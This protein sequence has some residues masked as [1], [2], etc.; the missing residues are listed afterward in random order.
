MWTALCRCIESLWLNFFILP[1]DLLCGHGN[2]MKYSR[3]NNTGVDLLVSELP[4]WSTSSSAQDWRINEGGKRS[5]SDSIL[6]Q[7]D[8]TPYYKL[9]IQ[10]GIGN[11]NN[12]ELCPPPFIF[13]VHYESI[14][15][16]T[17]ESITTSL[18]ECQCYI[19]IFISLNIKRKH[20]SSNWIT[21]IVYIISPCTI[22]CFP[23]CCQGSLMASKEDYPSS[24]KKWTE[25]W[26]EN[27]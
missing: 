2:R 4:E 24:N 8:D 23:P 19:G 17:G 21:C 11:N 26:I 25:Y 22:M 9:Q 1:H 5:R 27:A 6:T 20:I 12:C 13:Q 15:K 3:G 7:T 16:W 14:S 18:T 10:F